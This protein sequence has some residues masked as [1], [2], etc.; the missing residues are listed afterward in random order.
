MKQTKRKLAACLLIVTL[1]LAGPAAAEN[2]DPDQDGSQYAYGE[3]VGWLNF[4]PSQGDG[5]HV[6]ETELTGFIWGENIGWIKL[7]PVYGGV[8]NDDDGNLS[9]YA[10]GENVGWIK[11]NPTYA[12]VTINSEGNFDGY[13]W[14][15]NIGWIHF[16]AAEDYDVKVCVVD[17]E[18][19]AN[20]VADWL[21]SG[22]I[23]G[24][25]DE[26]ENVD[27]LDFSI[28]ASYWLSFCPDDWPL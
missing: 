24:N 10:W 23:P 13:A 20:F 11:F 5:V 9:G 6:N 14:G 27:L 7:D 8:S 12:G 15:E 17:L 16:D 4:E 1:L 18:N 21:Q 22:P 28:L 3:N 26:T 19:L 25:L 2:I